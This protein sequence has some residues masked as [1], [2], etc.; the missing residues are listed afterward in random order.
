LEFVDIPEIVQESLIDE[1]NF[2]KILDWYDVWIVLFT[3]KYLPL[4][5]SNN[6]R[7]PRP[8][9]YAVIRVTPADQT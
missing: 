3:S 1:E 5:L 7:F 2:R 8:N 6:I 9:S 4:K